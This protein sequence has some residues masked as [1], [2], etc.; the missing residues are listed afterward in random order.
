MQGTSELP[1][2]QAACVILC[3]QNQCPG[4][5]RPGVWAHTGPNSPDT[6][7]H[8]TQAHFFSWEAAIELLQVFH[9][10][11]VE[12]GCSAIEFLSDM[13]MEACCDCLQMT[14]LLLS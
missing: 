5:P 14:G 9:V 6:S 3:V 11:L 13:P 8:H 10:W 1:G 2:V 7:H 4:S 12:A